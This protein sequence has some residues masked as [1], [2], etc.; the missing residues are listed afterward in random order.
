MCVCVY[1]CTHVHTYIHTYIHICV[2]LHS[3]TYI[4]VYVYVYYVHLSC[5]PGCAAVR[6]ELLHRPSPTKTR[7]TLNHKDPVNP[8]P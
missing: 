8:K 2:T 7:S 6:S 4:N 3:I 1:V 5:N